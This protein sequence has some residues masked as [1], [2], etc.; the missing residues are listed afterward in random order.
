LRT[1]EVIGDEVDDDMGKFVD[2]DEDLL[3]MTSVSEDDFLFL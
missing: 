2:N 1:E 3:L